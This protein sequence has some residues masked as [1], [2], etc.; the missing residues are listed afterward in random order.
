[1]AKFIAHCL[2]FDYFDCVS[3]AADFIHIH[4]CYFPWT[5]GNQVAISTFHTTS[6]RNISLSF[7][8]GNFFF[9]YR[10]ALQF[11]MCV[12]T[13]PTSS[14]SIFQ[15]IGQLYAHISLF[16]RLSG[17][18]IASVV[19]Q[20]TISERQ[21]NTREYWQLNDRNYDQFW[22]EQKKATEIKTVIFW[23]NFYRPRNRSLTLSQ[24][25]AVPS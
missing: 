19:S 20:S 21:E 14:L 11:H 8:A 22:Y 25:S 9:N 15:T 18:E 13:V 10:I 17:I 6:Y 1:M 23:N 5:M 24:C 3:K 7:E 16:R 4:Q 2:R 12:V